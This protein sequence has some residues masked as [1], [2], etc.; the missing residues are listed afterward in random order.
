MR[1]GALKMN[2]VR[3]A[4][5]LLHDRM[6]V[7]ALAGERVEAFTIATENPAADR[8]PVNRRGR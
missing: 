8:S 2:P 4:I 7:T 1:L 3:L 5:V 6:A